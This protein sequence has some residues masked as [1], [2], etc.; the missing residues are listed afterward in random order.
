[1]LSYK[2]NPELEIIV[3]INQ[4]SSSRF[5]FQ[6]YLHSLEIFDLSDLNGYSKT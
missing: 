6:S 1:M 3:S 5:S 2:Q 4:V